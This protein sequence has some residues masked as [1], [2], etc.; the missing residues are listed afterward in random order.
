[1]IGFCRGCLIKYDEPFEL[2]QY[3]E[4]NR[5]LFVY[6]T[7]LQVK[8]NDAF[9][10]Q[11]CKDCYLNMK[12]ACK[13][14]KLCRTSDKRFKN[15]LSLKEIDDSLDLCNF[16][17][18]ND[19]NFSFRFPLMSGNSTPANQK[20]KDDDNESTCTSIR[21]FMTDMLQGEE[22]PDTEARIIKE[23]IEEEA[24][25]LDDSLDSHWLQ[26]DVSIDTDFKLDFS[27]SPFS[28]PRSVKNDHCYTP[29]KLSKDKEREELNYYT[30]KAIIEKP[31]QIE[32]LNIINEA[33][34]NIPSNDNENIFEEMVES[35]KN[36]LGSI[37]GVNNEALGINAQNYYV[38]RD[39]F[40]DNLE[41][42]EV[43]AK[44]SDKNDQCTID[45]NLEMALK[46]AATDKFSLDDLLVSP[47]VF[48]NGQMT[49]TIANILFSEKIESP[50]N[51][52]IGQ[53]I[54]NFQNVE[55][56][57]NLDGFFNDS[58]DYDTDN[59]IKEAI[60]KEYQNEGFIDEG[61]TSRNNN[62]I[63]SNVDQG[64]TK[65]DFENLN[66]NDTRDVWLIGKNF[67]IENFLCK[68]CE[69]K[70]ASLKALRLHSSK[71][72]KIKIILDKK[73]IVKF[74]EK[75]KEYYCE[76][77]GNK[78][79]DRIQF[80]RHKKTHNDP[81]K[82]YQCDIC[83]LICTSQNK[84]D[85][86]NKIHYPQTNDVK[87]K[88]YM[89]NICG[90]LFSTQTNFTLHQRRH[91]KSYKFYCNECGKGFYR[92]TDLTNHKRHHT[93][94]R[95]FQCLQCFQYFSLRN[96]LV[97]HIKNIHFGQKYF[98]CDCCNTKYKKKCELI[99]HVKKQERKRNRIKIVAGK[100][101]KF[102]V[103]SSEDNMKKFLVI[104]PILKDAIDH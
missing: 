31:D 76:T 58:Q 64:K 53:C 18:Q 7:G 73:V 99:K 4:K 61:E 57:C 85:Q 56:H 17:K 71:R 97:Q 8:R 88:K 67:D 50:T 3:T 42:I 87:E 62:E 89:C 80:F 32:E 5:R 93:L 43:N 101:K 49:P 19:D 100:T 37:D 96:S 66:E 29:L 35:P 84:L 36:Y 9:T 72:H 16:I 78:F 40:D 77:C 86:H 69:K 12:L 65:I 54:E 45:R 28:T 91:T 44:E 33:I 15:Y 52:N 26:D 25:V 103:S 68:L 79:K 51:Q 10:F 81:D 21:N 92:T 75:R 70:F 11:L 63:K 2:L 30:S 94:D 98:Q 23:V 20:L 24:D 27:F 22:M 41:S 102:C 39:I 83:L 74:S 90:K 38:Q 46:N 104:Q 82:V 48:S 34:N 13:F 60:D 55:G 95:P 47:P 59:I 6:S 1:M 14:K